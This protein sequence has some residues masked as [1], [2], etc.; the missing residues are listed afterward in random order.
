MSE[1]Q[2]PTPAPESPVGADTTLPDGR[3]WRLEEVPCDF[4]GS[5]DARV[6]I[7]GRDRLHGLPGQFGVVECARC[8]LV[9]TSPRPTLECLGAAYP[10]QYG[11]HQSAALRAKAPGGLLRWALINYRGYPLG[12]SSPVIT[13]TAFAPLG[14]LPL[15]SRRNLGY[16]PFTGQGRLLDFGCGVGGFVAKMNAAGWQ[17]EGMDLSEDAVRIG[18]EAGLTMHLGT[19]PALEAPDGGTQLEEGAYDALTMWQA[20]EHVPSP[21]AT[22]KAAWRLVRPGGRLLVAVPRFDSLQR[23]WFGPAWFPLDLP[24]HLTHFT[25]ATLERQIES[26]G[27]KVERTWPVRR[28]ANIRHSYA[29]LADDTGKARHRRLARSRMIVGMMSLWSLLRGGRTGQMICIAQKS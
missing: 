16:L 25:R 7:T 8:G 18:R 26:A 24:R 13:R 12:E 10:E 9:R 14:R 21:T 4:C 3:P 2:T 23:D 5:S 15:R 22:L 1:N 6:L 27:F 28:P 20:L 19:L 11:P 29:Y 17:A